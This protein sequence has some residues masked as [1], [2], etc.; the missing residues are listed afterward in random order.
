[1]ADTYNPKDP[2]NALIDT[3]INADIIL[4][5]FLGIGTTLLGFFAYIM[6]KIIKRILISVVLLNS[7]CLLVWNSLSDFQ[8]KLNNDDLFSLLNSSKMASGAFIT[9]FGL[10]YIK[11]LITE[12]RDFFINW[13]RSK[14]L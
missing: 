5:I 4:K 11:P 13:N 7:G 6:K 2:Q 14:K 10:K 9:M 12:L 8:S 3:T 1:M